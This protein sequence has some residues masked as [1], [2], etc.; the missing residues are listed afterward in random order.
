MFCADKVIFMVDSPKASA[1]ELLEVAF[2]LEAIEDVV[3]ISD[4]LHAEIDSGKSTDVNIL[5]ASVC[6][7]GC[8]LFTFPAQTSC[9]LF[10]CKLDILFT[11]PFIFLSNTLVL[12]VIL[13]TVISLE[14]VLYVCE[15]I[16]SFS[17]NGKTE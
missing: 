17:V 10:T 3:L 7:T 8:I 5:Y 1:S 15:N 4:T 9:T 16:K 12:L 2:I 11:E 14:G 13:V 6:T